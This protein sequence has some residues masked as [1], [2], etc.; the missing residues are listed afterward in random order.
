VTAPQQIQVPA[1]LVCCTTYGQIRGETAQNL[2]EMRSHSERNGLTNVGWAMIPGTLVEKARND[3]V[4]TML[5]AFNGDAKWL[6]FVDGDMTFAPD[7]LQ[8]VLT[9]AY[10][11]HPWADVV[12]AY[13][14]LKGDVGLPTLDTGTGTWESLYPNSGVKECIRTGAAFLLCK[15][16]VFERLQQPWFRVRQP[17][18]FLDALAEI[19][20]WARMKMDGQ[21]PFRGL[22]GSPWEKLEEIAASDPSSAP[23]GYQVV[24]VGE[25]SGFC[26]R[27]KNAGFRIAVDTGI[28]VGHLETIVR[29]WTHHKKKIQ[30]I[31]TQ[32]LQAV[33]VC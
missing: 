1:G 22:P 7:S 19:D 6:L 20:N 32:W 27:V 9:T 12:G 18:R 33:G 31:E 23:G 15:R 30:E 28:Q 14:T 17:Q 16:H 21:N 11:S 8:R 26:D 25:D 10:G 29:D 5:G 4:R 24:E 3:A 2:M 13:C